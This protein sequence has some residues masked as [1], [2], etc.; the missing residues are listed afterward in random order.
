M[1]ILGDYLSGPTRGSSRLRE[2]LSVE[3]LPRAHAGRGREGRPG[4][5][6]QAGDRVNDGQLLDRQS[7]SLVGRSDRCAEP[8]RDIPPALGAGEMVS[9]ALHL[10]GGAPSTSPR[11]LLEGKLRCVARLPPQVQ[12]EAG[13]SP[14]LYL[15]VTASTGAH[16]R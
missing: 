8:R 4:R 12:R 11:C 9:L 13:R 16:F 1:T 15:A 10:S 3:Y 5:A 2:K 7:N 14:V 6:S